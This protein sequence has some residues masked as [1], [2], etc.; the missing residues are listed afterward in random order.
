MAVK[1]A[2]RKAKPVSNPNLSSMKRELAATKKQL[3]GTQLSLNHS[4]AA[5]ADALERLKELEK[6]VA[7]IA[8]DPVVA[9]PHELKRR[10]EEH[11]AKQDRD[12]EQ[13]AFELAGR[14]MAKDLHD[15]ASRVKDVE[16]WRAAAQDAQD[17]HEDRIDALE[18]AA[19]SDKP[20]LSVV[21]NQQHN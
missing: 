1:N 16:E 3:A 11:E 8:A 2:K 14:A 12:R 13:M 5:L 9:V 21:P 10:F 6:K 15:L 19:T 17:S 4:H 20:K 7:R 18:E